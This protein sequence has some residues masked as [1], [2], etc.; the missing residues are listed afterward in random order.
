MYV[1]SPNLGTFTTIGPRGEQTIIKKIPVSS[2]FGYMIIDRSTSQ[3][4]Y[5]ECGKT[6]LRTLEFNLKDG[7]GRYVP[8]HNANISFSLVFSIKSED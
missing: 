3:H 5:L 7:R 2:E 8:L 4:D 6:T 1:S